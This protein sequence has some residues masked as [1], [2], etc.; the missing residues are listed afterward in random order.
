MKAGDLVTVKSGGR[1][2]PAVVVYVRGQSVRVAMGEK[3]TGI[4]RTIPIERVT[5]KRE[6]PRI[7]KVETFVG[8]ASLMKDGPAEGPM[9][10]VQSELVNEPLY[11]LRKVPKP[12]KPSRSPAYLAFVRTQMCCSC[13]A[14]GPCEAHHFGPRGMSQK[15]D[16]FHAV[17]L[18]TSCHRLFHDK[19]EILGRDRKATEE[20]FAF[21]KQQLLVSW[22]YR[23]SGSYDMAVNA[24][25]GALR[26]SA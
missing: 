15:A 9:N 5:P 18:C 4:N 20:R 24:L 16:D 22:A 23:K 12:P 25:V 10:R 3:G 7:T 1:V 14:S 17:P 8:P 21:I 26:E 13:N 6:I 2:H 19:G 11:E